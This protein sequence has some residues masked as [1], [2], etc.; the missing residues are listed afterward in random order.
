MDDPNWRF[1]GSYLHVEANYQ[2]LV[3]NLLDTTHLPFLHP[4]SL[5]TD[6]MRTNCP[7]FGFLPASSMWLARSFSPLDRNS[8]AAVTRRETSVS[9]RRLSFA[10]PTGRRRAP[11]R[12]RRSGRSR[13]TAFAC[14]TWP[15]TPGSG[16]STGRGQ[17]VLHPAELAGRHEGRLV[18]LGAAPVPRAPARGEGRL[19]PVRRRL[20]PPLPP[21]RPPPAPGRHRHEPRGLP[22]GSSRRPEL[23]PADRPERTSTIRLRTVPNCVRTGTPGAR[24]AR[25]WPFCTPSVRLRSGV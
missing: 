21:R 3:E 5:G 13:P 23:M 25:N 7:S 17:A 19:V 9:S 14:T 16:R 10:S 15:V 6:G 18:R 22:R 2:L 11:A 24:S 20:L 1:G 4:A 8:R 12:R